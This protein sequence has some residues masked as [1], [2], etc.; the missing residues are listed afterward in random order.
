LEFLT[1]FTLSV[2]CEEGII[3][4]G[5]CKKQYIDPAWYIFITG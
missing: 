1:G 3:R 2:S 4:H 5:D